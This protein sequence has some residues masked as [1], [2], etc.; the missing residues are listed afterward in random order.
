MRVSNQQMVSGALGQAQAQL[1]ALMRAETQLSTG[2]RLS[3]PSDDPAA[4]NTILLLQ[5]ATQTS[6]IYAYHKHF[7]GLGSAFQRIFQ[8]ARSKIIRTI[9]K[10]FLSGSG[11]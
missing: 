2:Q 4:A 6:S 11:F 1:A 3:A 5:A 8:D 9:R 10:E 7:R